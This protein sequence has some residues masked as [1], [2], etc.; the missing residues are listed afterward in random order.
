MESILLGAILRFLQAAS[1]AAPTLLIGVFT[2]AYLERMVG[3]AKTRQMFGHGTWRSL[4]LAWLI[5]M[6]LPVC[7]LGC[8]PV[9]VYL[10]RAGI[11]TGAILAFAISAPL[12][13]PISILWGLT[14][15]D[16]VAILSFCIVSLIVVS[17]VGLVADYCTTTAEP[18][19]PPENHAYG[20]KRVTAV[21]MS[22]GQIVT[23]RIVIYMFL[24]LVGVALLSFFLPRGYLQA[25]AERNDMYAP[26]FMG[27][28]AMPAYETPLTAIVKLGDMFQHGN[29]VGAA[30]TLLILGAG[31]NLGL[32]V[33]SGAQ[34]GWRSTISFMGA[35]FVVA[36][37]SGYLIDKPLTPTG[38]D[39]AGHTHAFDVYCNPFDAT[40]EITF[41]E[42][43]DKWLQG[44]SGYEMVAGGLLLLLLAIDLLVR[45][46]RQR[47]RIAEWVNQTAGLKY[48][49]ELSPK[50][51]FGL[52]IVG[53]LAGSV[54]SCYLFYPPREEIMAEMRIANV[55]I[56]SAATS[57]SWDTVEYWLPIQDSWTRKLEVSMFLRL[58]EYGPFEQGKMSILRDKLDLLK[59][60]AEDKDPEE[61]HQAAMAMTKAYSRL[62]EAVV[63]DPTGGL[64]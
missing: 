35:L 54:F 29:S 53:L 25:S 32:I 8:L 24:G 2:A 4:P 62:R 50:T 56:G 43:V 44:T 37:I 42:I 19:A 12:F 5:G 49:R 45:L 30:L 36:V 27:F 13:N 3:P 47:H 34:F 48:D 17:I 26:L 41:S 46:S 38:I 31:M 1:L 21:A 39:A 57:Q 28:V 14:L 55:E 63:G 60:A 40:F 64:Q 6:S 58:Q 16:P 61:A 23:H 51:M 7:S 52:A 20:I 15:S 22:M 59:H 33:W 10:R 18:G 9:L 11:T